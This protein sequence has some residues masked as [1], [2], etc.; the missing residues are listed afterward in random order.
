MPHFIIECS[1]NLVKERSAVTILDTVYKTAESTGLF[2]PNDIK[3]RI[4]AYSDYQLG[5]G[6]DS[7]LHVFAHIM[8]G[9]TT[10]Q[11]AEL[12]K[13]IVEKLNE[14]LPGLSFLSMNVYEFERATYCNK[15]IINP[16]NKSGDRHFGV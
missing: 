4:S 15:A 3:V 16:K 14:L 9:R 2:A 7:F 8:E 5:K 10:E 6:K 11:K 13:R 12:S 1:Q